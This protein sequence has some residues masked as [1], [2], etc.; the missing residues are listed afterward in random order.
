MGLNYDFSTFLSYRSL[1]LSFCLSPSSRARTDLTIADIPGLNRS[2]VICDNN[3][4]ICHLPSPRSFDPILT[5]FFAQFHPGLCHIFYTH[6]NHRG[7]ICHCYK[8]LCNLYIH[9]FH[10]FMGNSESWVSF[11]ESSS[12]F[13]LKNASIWGSK[14][15]CRHQKRS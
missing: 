11:Q 13:C 15:F 2:P 6:S 5:L 3:L 8:H 1:L 10:T 12:E 4:A 9:V 14:G 7:Q